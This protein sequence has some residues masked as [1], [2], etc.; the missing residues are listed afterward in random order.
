MTDC[1]EAADL[2]RRI[3]RA[4]WFGRDAHGGVP[5]DLKPVWRQGYDE[6]KREVL[7]ALEAPAQNRPYVHVTESE[8]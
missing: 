3:R 4:L 7:A 1:A 8:N 2:K 6:A 5:F